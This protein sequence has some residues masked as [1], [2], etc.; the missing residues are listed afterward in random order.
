M[1]KQ[2]LRKVKIHGMQASDERLCI[3]RKHEERVNIVKD[4]HENPMIKVACY[5]A[6]Q[7]SK[8]IQVGR[9]KQ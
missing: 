3:N 1:I 2:K 9:K 8:W 4:V 5:M 7:D 6:Y